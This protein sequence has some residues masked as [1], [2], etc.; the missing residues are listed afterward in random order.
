MYTTSLYFAALCLYKGGEIVD[1]TT[2]TGLNGY[3]KNTFHI[4]GMSKEHYEDLADIF[5]RKQ[6]TIKV[7]VV[8]FCE[9][10][11]EARSFMP[12]FV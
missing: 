12:G 6:G 7:D 11:K 2:E 3:A 9:R 4:G 10:I 5:F 8:E 1:V